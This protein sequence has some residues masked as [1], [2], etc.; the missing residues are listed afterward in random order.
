MNW[1]DGVIII[2][3]LIYLAEGLRR[4]FFEQTMELIGF[5]VTIFLAV[6]TYQPLA[7]WLVAHV[8]LQ[9]VASGPIGFLIDW[10]ILQSLYSLFLHLTYPMI[11]IKWRMNRPNHIAGVVPALL[12]AYII[13]S[14]LVTMIAVLQVPTR[15]K[16]EINNS[17]F[18]S[19]FVSQSGRV[20]SYFNRIFGRDLKESLTFITVPAQNEQVIGPNDKVDLKFTTEEVTVDKDSEQK[21]FALLNDERVKEG[22]PPLIWDEKLAIV[23]R[24]HSAD[25]FK[26]GYFAHENPD[27]E[28]PFDRMKK[29]G[30]RYEAAGENLAYASNVNLAHN[31]LMR[32]P[33]HRANILE[34]DFGKI[35]LGVIDGGIY[36]KMFTQN[37]TD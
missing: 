35:G 18:G 21:M 28:S 16:N 15:L 17:T 22:L 12:K 3:F 26:R 36:G 5:F 4:G 11:P 23:A 9:K 20:E 2:T 14:I 25:M 1:V 32:S 30:V 7:D 34:K 27:G 31:G 24:A 29:G 6:W 33:G 19:R 37:F 13:I 8:G 10:V